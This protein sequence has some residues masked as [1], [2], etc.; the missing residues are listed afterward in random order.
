M[1]GGSNERGE[2]TTLTDHRTTHRPSRGPLSVWVLFI[3]TLVRDASL[4]QVFVPIAHPL[5]LRPIYFTNL[6]QSFYFTEML[7]I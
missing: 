7:D 6:R 3:E 1:G 5:A 2:A 4:R